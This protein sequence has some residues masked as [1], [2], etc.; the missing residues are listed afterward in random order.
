MQDAIDR[1]DQ[2]HLEIQDHESRTMTFA[3]DNGRQETIPMIQ[4]RIRQRF[5]VYA[6]A[7]VPLNEEIGR[8]AI[9]RALYDSLANHEI[10][11]IVP[12]PST[13]LSSAYRWMIMGSSGL[14]R[15]VYAVPK[16]ME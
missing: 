1:G 3:K 10:T 7:L 5:S 14:T 6:Q 13:A 11:Y 2:V 12:P 8:S 15:A 16:L 4:I 9:R